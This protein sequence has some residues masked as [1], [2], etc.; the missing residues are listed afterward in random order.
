M[1]GE[2]SRA[3]SADDVRVASDSQSVASTAQSAPNPQSVASTAQS[4]PNP[5]QAPLSASFETG[6]RNKVHHSYIWLAPIAATFA[7]AAAVIVYNVGDIIKAYRYV[8]QTTGSGIEVIVAAV[9]GI[10]LAAYGIVVAVHAVAY[11]FL[12]FEFGEREFNL[13]SGFITKKHVHVPYARVQSVNHRASILQRIFGVCSVDIDTA[14]G[15]TNK[16]VR[17]PYVQLSTAERIRSELFTRKA[18][19]VAGVPVIFDPARAA[20]GVGGRAQGSRADIASAIDSQVQR[21]ESPVSPDQLVRQH[22]EGQNAAPNILEETAGAV[23]TWRG[24]YGGELLEEEPVSYEFGLAN[25]ELL[26]TGFSHSTSITLGLIMS[27]CALFASAMLPSLV[28]VGVPVEAAQEAG[29]LIVVLSIGAMIVGWALGILG[30][31]LQFG[32]FRARRRG[33]RIEV[34]RGLLAREFSGIDIARVQSVVIKQGFIR[35][36]MGYCEISLGRIDA[37]GDESSS[38]GGAKLNQGGLV[39]HP[40]VKTNR[41]AEVLDGLVPEFA[42]LPL[43]S[44]MKAPPQVALRRAVMRRCIWY[45]G[46]L[47]WAACMLVMR[48]IMVAI[49]SADPT[50]MGDQEGFAIAFSAVDVLLVVSLVALAVAIV[51]YAVSAV[52]WQRHSRF[53]TNAHFAVFYNDGLTTQRTIIPRTK[54]QTGYTRTNPFQ[55]RSDVSTVLAVSAAGTSNT[56][57]R[58]MDLRRQDAREWLEWMIPHR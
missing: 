38:N 58:I 1:T 9:L 13:Y 42:D 33:D 47:W 43:E 48:Q 40:F 20:L 15:A 21:A 49:I 45:N 18:A 14:G 30:I 10:L 46:I 23:G 52:L 51:F 56:V 8:S 34:E 53:G 55:R 19:V 11:K 12:S 39:V 31:C 32:G 54:I 3:N 41:V 16:A 4:A 29:S 37:G 44:D 22:A 17:V 24:A 7:V 57:L 28:L 36:C 27:L 6:A 35:R 25:K 26:L 5:Q 50:A 2:K